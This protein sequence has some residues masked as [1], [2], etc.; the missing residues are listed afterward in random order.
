M[1]AV[2]TLHD[3][4]NTIANRLGRAIDAAENSLSGAYET[5]RRELIL[6]VKVGV[7]ELRREAEVQRQRTETKPLLQ[8]DGHAD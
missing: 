7:R 8:E 2:T 3:R 5:K 4:L 6:A 1:P